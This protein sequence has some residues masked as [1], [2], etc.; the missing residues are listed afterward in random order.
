MA[1]A[2]AALAEVSI[3]LVCIHFNFEFCKNIAEDQSMRI[4]DVS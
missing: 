4:I 3:Y 1:E 2:V